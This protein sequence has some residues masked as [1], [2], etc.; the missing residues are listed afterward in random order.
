[1]TTTQH[2]TST[3]SRQLELDAYE[4]DSTAQD[5]EGG[6]RKFRSMDLDERTSAKSRLP[7]EVLLEE[8]SIDRG[9]GWSEIARL[10]GVS[11]SAVRKWRAGESISSESR[12]SL[13][14]LT[15]FLDLLQEVGPVGE[16]A[17]WLNMRK[18]IGELTNCWTTARRTGA[19]LPAQ[20]GRSSSFLT[21]NESLHGASDGVTLAELAAPTNPEDLWLA[22][23]PASMRSGLAN[24]GTKRT[25]N[26]SGS[27]TARI[28][29]SG[30]GWAK[31]I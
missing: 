21:V 20:N 14:R 22:T 3:R 30:A 1:M 8:L 10:C 18:G 15:A 19:P 9:L 4:H 27:L 25:M 7:T 12:R 5:V 13:A 24:P 16:P 29:R 2:R 11:V 23:G 17:G 26:L 28:A 31:P 6:R